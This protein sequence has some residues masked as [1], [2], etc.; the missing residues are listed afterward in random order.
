MEIFLLCQWPVRPKKITRGRLGR[1]NKRRK[2][3]PTRPLV[4][5]PHLAVRPCLVVEAFLDF[6]KVSPT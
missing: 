2:S 5:M 4:S 3:L 6:Q 1:N